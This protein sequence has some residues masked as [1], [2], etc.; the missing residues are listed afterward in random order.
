[1]RRLNTVALVG[2]CVFL[3]AGLWGTPARAQMTSGGMPSGGGGAPSSGTGGGFLNS[4]TGSGSSGFLNSG[5]GSGSSGFLNSGTGTG[6]SGFLSTGT[7]GTGL[8]GGTT[9][10][11]GTRTGTGT[12]SQG[13]S[14]SNPLGPNYIN[15]MTLGLPSGTSKPRFGSPM[16]TVT[17]STT[18]GANRGGTATISGSTNVQAFPGASS[19]GVRRNPAYATTVGFD[20]APPSPGSLQTK[21]QD[22]IARA[23][24]QLKSK[25]SILVAMDGDMLVLRGTASN[26]SERRLAE[27][28]VRMTP[29]IYDVRNELEVPEPAPPPRRIP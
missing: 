5:T 25:D 4:G 7:S 17:T 12:S 13:I 18:Q 24:K 2:G 22:A 21:A 14:S 9:T 8:T 11:G 15:L 23:S 3:I 16:Y 1:M 28:I 6:S 19:V 20:Y 10:G 29:G 26:A 27:A